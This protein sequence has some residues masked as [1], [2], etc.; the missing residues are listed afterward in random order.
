MPMK[1]GL[2]PETSK[3]CRF[4]WKRFSASFRFLFHLQSVRNFGYLR[5]LSKRLA[6]SFEVRV[7]IGR[8]SRGG[9]GTPVQRKTRTTLQIYLHASSIQTF[10]TLTEIQ[11]VKES[12]DHHRTTE[13]KLGED[14]EWSQQKWNP[15]YLNGNEIF[16]VTMFDPAPFPKSSQMQR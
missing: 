11:S 3:K 15:T 10:H 14:G 12:G 8:V 2:L 1:S 7:W 4:F 13:Y 6:G 9:G 16:E 5:R